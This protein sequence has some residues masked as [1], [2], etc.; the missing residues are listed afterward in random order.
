MQKW[1]AEAASA[2][3]LDPRNGDILAM[4]VERGYD[5]NRFPIVP[6]DLQRNRAVTDTYEP[7]STFKV[8]TVSAALSE[9]LVSPSTAFTLPYEIQV[10]D[11]D[12]PRRAR[13]RHGADDG[14]RDHLQVVE[15]RHD[16]AG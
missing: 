2:V 7:G 4:A 8:V 9:G 12:D 5:A 3:V 14:R 16:H 6:R 10:A 15:R 1:G 13:A 11:R